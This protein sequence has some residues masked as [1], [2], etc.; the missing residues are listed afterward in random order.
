MRAMVRVYTNHHHINLISGSW[1]HEPGLLIYK[2]AN[3]GSLRLGKYLK[4]C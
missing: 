3:L 1:R 4:A 2:L